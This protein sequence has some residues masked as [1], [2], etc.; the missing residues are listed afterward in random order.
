MCISFTVSLGDLIVVQ[1]CFHSCYVDNG[2][3]AGP[4]CATTSVPSIIHDHGPSLSLFIRAKSMLLS[5]DQVCQIWEILESP[6]G[7]KEFCCE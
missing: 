2:V 5:K 6:I 3:V 1:S 4:R 7:D